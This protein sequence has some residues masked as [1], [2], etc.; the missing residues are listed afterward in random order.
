MKELQSN[1][2]TFK[3]SELP[4]EVKQLFNPFRR[5][6]KVINHLTTL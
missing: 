1:H 4:E 3:K 2:L 6:N 5:E